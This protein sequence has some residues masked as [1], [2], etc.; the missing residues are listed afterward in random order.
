[1]ACVCAHTFVKKMICISKIVIILETTCNGISNPS[2]AHEIYFRNSEIGPSQ[3]M[4]LKMMYFVK[5]AEI[6]EKYR[7]RAETSRSIITMLI[8]FSSKN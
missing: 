8:P 2:I 4:A 7:K 5:I 6:S 1:M 3:K